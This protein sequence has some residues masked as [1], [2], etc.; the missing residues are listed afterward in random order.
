MVSTTDVGRLYVFGGYGPHIS[1]YLHGIGEF[2]WDTVS[3][4]LRG[5]FS[6]QPISQFYTHDTGCEMQ[7]FYLVHHP[8]QYSYFITLFKPPPLC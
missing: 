1:E 8:S 7:S 6:V 3:L 5:I 2:V 4:F